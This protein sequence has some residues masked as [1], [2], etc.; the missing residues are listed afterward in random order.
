MT[1]T[2]ALLALPIV[3]ADTTSPTD[4]LVR[5][6]AAYA[7][8]YRS[9][10]G[11]DLILD[12]G[13]VRRT[14]RLAPNAATIGLR[15]LRGGAEQV[16]AVRP[17]ALVT[18]G[19]TPYPVGGLTGQPNHAFL[20]TQWLETMGSAPD[21]FLCTGFS[22]GKTRARFAWAPQPEG[23]VW[24]P[25]GVS[26]D[27]TFAPPAG[28]P[29]CR[30]I[31]HYE[32][33]DGLPVLAKWLT[34]TN[35]GATPVHLTRFVSETLAVVEPESIVENAER[36]EDAPLTVLTDYAFGGM[37]QTNSNRTARWES[38][39]DY[40][41]QVNYA[42]QTP[43]LLTVRPPVGPDAEV[44]PGASLETFRTFLVLHDSTERERRSLTV[45]RVY[46]ALAPWSADNPLMLHLTSTDPAVVRQ[47]IDQ[48]A[49]VGFEL[50][51]I[52]F[53]SGLDMEDLSDANLAK[54]KALA[55]YAHGKGI[56]LGGY[57][58]LASRRISDADD[59][60]HPKT[61]T[62]GGAIFDNSPCLGS[63]WGIRY[64]EKLRTF[65]E[66][67]GFDLL[68]HDGSYPGDVCASTRHPGH[69]GLDD[70]QWTQFQQIAALYR[71]CRG[72]GIFLNVPD[73]YFLNGSNKTGMGYRE[74]NWSLPRAEQ[75]LH[76]RQNLF[77]GTWEKTPSM[78]WMMVPLV[79][80]QGGGP[81]ATIEPLKDHLSDYGGHLAN[82]LGYGA[83]A[84]Y[85]GPRLFDA[86]ET[87]ALVAGWVRWFKK[88]RAIL[89]SDVIHLRRAD[90]RDW[91]GILHVNP[92]LKEKGLAAL[93]NP[94][95]EPITRT[96]TLPLYYTGLTEKARV[97]SNDTGRAV[98]H[99]LDRDYTIRI[100]VTLPA[101]GMVWLTI[102]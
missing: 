27:L 51:V 74:S 18:I 101:A 59:C 22:V 26:L 49:Q 97:K 102:Q 87:K 80:Y 96:I 14:F 15:A 98:T 8:V 13:L 30:V 71:W 73:W 100:D 72:R 79:E 77:D 75:Q 44:A 11:K 55:D 62:T 66:K 25:P 95:P 50:I 82:C 4:W 70:S 46:R 17:E 37:A 52:S 45:R 24:P 36:W 20:K 48:C 92:A 33:Y 90:G 93:Y 56:R 60:I 19:G 41:T 76:A 78:G 47:A 94:L 68:E 34:V 40:A 89:E 64:F 65:L 38:D 6:P 9:A 61:G 69:R 84:C 23:A 63:A 5:P 53:W 85:R 21:A 10:D 42:R 54:F 16:R 35:D 31:V 67:T 7:A 28:G 39:P 99:R 3:P 12:N 83:Q 86:P 2:A 1:L 88:H 57:S 91:D 29:S 43:C 58:L 32:L 81:E